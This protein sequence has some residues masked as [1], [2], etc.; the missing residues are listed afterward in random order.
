MALDRKL[1]LDGRHYK[2]QS[3]AEVRGGGWKKD[4]EIHN[5]IEALNKMLQWSKKNSIAKAAK[6]IIGANLIA[7]HK[8]SFNRIQITFAHE[9]QIGKNKE[10]CDFKQ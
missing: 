6:K 7:P 2:T 9:P 4:E 1:R 3:K 8:T 10:N 5:Q